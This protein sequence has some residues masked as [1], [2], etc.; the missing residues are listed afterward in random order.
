MMSAKCSTTQWLTKPLLSTVVTAPRH[1][2]AACGPQ[3]TTIFQYEGAISGKWVSPGGRMF[4]SDAVNPLGANVLM[5]IWR[6]RM[7]RHPIS[8]TAYVDDRLYWYRSP[9]GARDILATT[10]DARTV[11]DA[12]G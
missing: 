4:Q 1:I 9:H 5:N 3:A 10:T 8:I 6:W 7:Q 2:G 11:D 12:L